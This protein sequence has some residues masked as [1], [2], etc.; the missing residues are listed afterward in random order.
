MTKALVDYC[1]RKTGRS[2]TGLGMLSGWV[3]IVCNL[4]LALAKIGAG[5]AVK[6]VAVIGDGVNNLTDCASSILTLLGFRLARRPADREHPFGHGRY[7]YVA[8][9]AVAALVLLAGAELGISSIKKIWHPEPMD[10]SRMTMGVLLASCLVKLWLWAFNRRLGAEISSG[11]LKAAAADSRNDAIATAVVAL[12]LAG[13]QLLNISLDGFGGL[14][15]AAFI[16]ISGGKLL[17]D[18]LSPLLG[19]PADAETVQALEQLICRHDGILGIHD[20]L[21][22]DYGPGR[23]FAT[24]HAELDAAREP[25]Q[26]HDLLDY[27]EKSA[28]EQL[29]IR[30]VIHYDPVDCRWASYREAVQSW[31]NEAAPEVS[32]HDLRVVRYHD[33]ENLSLDLAVPF[34]YSV[35]DAELTEGVIGALM[36]AGW[37]LPVQVHIDRQD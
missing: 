8:G 18:T 16:L 5:L 7:E 33:A 25:L 36:Q 26:A 29:G 20:L 15:V 4:A 13:Q 3:G 10:F 19:S 2:H 9:L 6:S 34:D 14:A 30:L 35:E 28:L 37:E 31:L 27:I 22:H 1:I 32:V 24:V 12:C 17:G 21:I 11:A 23:C